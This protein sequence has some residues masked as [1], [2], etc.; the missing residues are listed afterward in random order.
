VVFDAAHHV[1]AVSLAAGK[2]PL[3]ESVSQDIERFYESL[4]SEAADR[5]GWR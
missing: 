3:A 5:L 4:V 2:N 1:T